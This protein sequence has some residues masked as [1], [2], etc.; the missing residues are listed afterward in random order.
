MAEVTLK[1]EKV[2][3]ANGFPQVG[4]ILPDFELVA[5]DLSNRTLNDFRG[6]QKLIATVPSLDTEVCSLET[7]K[8]YEYALHHP[9]TIFFIISSDLPFA[10][11]R[12]CKDHN[13]SNIVFLSV[14]RN[15]NFS[16]NYGLLIE[17]GPLSGIL[18]RSI[19][20]VD[21]KDRVLY[22]ELVS[23]ITDE[24]NYSAAFAV[25]EK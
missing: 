20:I 14:M 6:K 4:E 8:L 7:K 3:I 16:K 19:L 18:T 17:S 24:P 10:Q 9:E 15:Q 21:E 2:K 5:S 23:E 12:F 1:G 13:I 11:K 25:L 22:R